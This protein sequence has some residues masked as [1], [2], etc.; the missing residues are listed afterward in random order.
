[1]C[2]LEESNEQIQKNQIWEHPLD[3]IWVYAFKVLENSCKF[4]KKVMKNLFLKSAF[5]VSAQ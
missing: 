2:F 3:E 1:M 5:T 4:W